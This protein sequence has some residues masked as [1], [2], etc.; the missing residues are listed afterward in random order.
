MKTALILV[1]LQ[2]DFMPGGPLAVSQADE[3][4]PLANELMPEYEF[5]IATQDWHPPTHGSFAK[6]HP[7][8]NVFDQTELNGLPQTLWPVHCVEHTTGAEF[9]PDLQ[10]DLITQIFPKGT[11]PGIDSYSG[12]FDNGRRSGTGL[13]EWLKAHGLT[14]VDILGVATDYCVKYTALD[15]RSLGLNTRLLLAGCRGVNLQEDDIANAIR[16][17]EEAGVE[18]IHTV[19]QAPGYQGELK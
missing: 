7:G 10:R 12:F 2:N 19:N 8:K 14:A 1:D 16:E 9:H 4:I 5:V 6:N 13:Q 17:M 15:A 18:C 3:V 11:D